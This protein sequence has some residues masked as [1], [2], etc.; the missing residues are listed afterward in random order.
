MNLKNIKSKPTP[1]GKAHGIKRCMCLQIVNVS[2]NE[3]KLM[4]YGIRDLKLQQSSH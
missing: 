4:T 1:V 2:M 3:T